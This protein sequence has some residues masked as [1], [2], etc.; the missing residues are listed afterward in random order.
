MALCKRQT[1]GTKSFQGIT[2]P[3]RSVQEI[4]R[5][6]EEDDEIKITI[7]EKY[8]QFSTEKLKIITRTIEGNFPDYENVLPV[9][10]TNIAKIEKEA[11][12]KGLKKVSAIIG[13]SEPIKITLTE[14]NMEID[15]ESDIGRAKEIIGIE[16]E[17]EKMTMNFNVR[18]IFD[19][20]TH[21]AGDKVVMM[22]PSTYGAVLFMGEEEKNYKNIVMPIRV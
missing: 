11:L 12:L 7:E 4:E 19:V 18:F 15:A 13:R 3:K 9:S 20:V 10:N 21:I 1:K 16:Y 2:I 17:G 22:A 14:K 8:V 5:V 6:I